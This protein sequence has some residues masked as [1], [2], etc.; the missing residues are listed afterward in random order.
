[1]TKSLTA[2]FHVRPGFEERVERLVVELTAAVRQEPGNVM[3][4]PH[5]NAAD[6]RHYVI[7][8]VYRDDEAFRAHLGESHGKR[9]N[10]ALAECIEGESSSL[11][12]LDS[13]EPEQ[14]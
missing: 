4:L 3:F 7:F 12:H 8:E 1:M 11:T 9:F 10:A 6:P 13:I 14:A 5:V 2:E